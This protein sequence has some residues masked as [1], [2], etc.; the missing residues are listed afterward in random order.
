[1]LSNNFS[2]SLCKIFNGNLM[3]LICIIFYLAWWTVIFKHGKGQK[4]RQAFYI[5]VAFIAGILSIL[6]ITAG[7]AERGQY[8]WVLQI[9]FILIGTVLLFL[10][11]LIITT[12]ALHRPLTSELIIIHIWA[13]LEITMIDVIFSNGYLSHVAVWIYTA[14]VAISILASLFC[15]AVY[16]RLCEEARY[17]T[18]MIPLVLAGICAIV[19]LLMFL[20]A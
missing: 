3:L 2:P 4:S 19:M 9:K 10:V 18:G 1:M 13:L 14:L 11:L 16:Y 7:I 20:A 5:T 6:S 17:Q 15:Y 8:P 12:K